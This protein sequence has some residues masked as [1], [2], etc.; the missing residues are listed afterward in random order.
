MTFTKND[1]KF[2]KK[3]KQVATISDF[4]KV[5][6]GC[7]AVYRGQVIGIGCNTNKTH[8]YQAKYNKLRD[9]IWTE[10]KAHAEIA[11]LNQIKHMDLKWSKVKLY[12]F[13][14]RY[15][16]PYGMCRP[17]SACMGAIKD[18]GIKNIY[19]TTDN[20]YVYEEII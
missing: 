20:G 14:T 17:C 6:I 18:I 3:A 7:V 1:Y 10:H 5:H 19:Y 2:F 12:I 16:K 8:P 9:D 4:N 15:D 11:C 13:R